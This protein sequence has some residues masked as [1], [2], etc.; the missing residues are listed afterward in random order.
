[1]DNYEGT[2]MKQLPGGVERVSIPSIVAGILPT[3]LRGRLIV[4]AAAVAVGLVSF[5]LIGPWAS[6]PSTYSGIIESLDAKR[7]TVLGLIGG[8][9]AV[10]GVI[11][12]LPGDAGTP[13]AEKLLDVSGD[14]GFVLGAIFLEKYLL[15]IFGFVA[16]KILIPIACGLLAVAALLTGEGR[17]YRELFLSGTLRLAIF[18]LAIALVVP[19]S[20]FIS[21]AIDATYQETMS[22]TVTSA[23]EASAMAT[24]IVESEESSDDGF[25]P[26]QWVQE[27][28]E[29]VSTA[30]T[31]A[32]EKA[33]EA[34][35]GFIEALAVMIVT[36][37][38]IPILV[39]LALLWVAKT[40]LG[41]KVNVP[42]SAFT[43]RTFRGLAG[44]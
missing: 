42:I 18:G 26:L 17:R 30:V 36:S 35:T 22:Q 1:M 9:A 31:E 44:R 13:I 5:F 7:D 15:T 39:L 3:S 4:V 8:S 33:Q 19:A 37:C 25:H 41:L 20:V 10:S 43:P 23:E 28:P 40:I 27:L 34:L 24:Q 11:T 21:D 2:H 12:L 29:N 14:L 38:V 32:T 16:T 6:S